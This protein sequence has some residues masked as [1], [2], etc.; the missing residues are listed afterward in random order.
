MGAGEGGG[1]HVEMAGRMVE[2]FWVVKCNHSSW[3]SVSE[4]FVK[5]SYLVRTRHA[6]QV[7]AAALLILQQSKLNWKENIYSVLEIK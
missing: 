5:A 7:T 1:G 3:N 4:S 2:C 6:H